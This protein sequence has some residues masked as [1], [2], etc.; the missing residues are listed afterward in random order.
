MFVNTLTHKPH[1]QTH[2]EKKNG[3]FKRKTSNPL[4]SWIWEEPFLKRNHHL[5][6]AQDLQ[7]NNGEASVARRLGRRPRPKAHVPCSSPWTL[8]ETLTCRPPSH[9]RAPLELR[10]CEDKKHLAMGRTLLPSHQSLLSASYRLGNQEVC[11]FT[12]IHTTT[13]GL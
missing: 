12:W 8:W 4:A 2:E 9:S 3:K 10:P 1:K 11:I 5:A 7:T 6:L 13:Y